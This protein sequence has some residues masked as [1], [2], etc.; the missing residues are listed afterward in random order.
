MRM[1]IRISKDLS[2]RDFIK[3]SALA[4]AG[5]MIDFRFDSEQS[6]LTRLKQA[7][8]GLLGRVFKD[9]TASYGDPS[10]AA[11]RIALHNYN[12]VLDLKDAIIRKTDNNARELWYRLGDGSFIHSHDIQP[13]KN[14]LYAPQSEIP[15]NGLLAEVTVPYT[16]AWNSSTNGKKP[17]QIFFYGSTHWVYGFGQDEQ[18]N[19]YYLVKEDR[20]NHSYYVNATHMR[21]VQD[22][23]LLPISELIPLDNKQ[24]LIDLQ[25]QVMIAYEKNEPVYMS[26]L[27]SGQLKGKTDLSTPMGEY[28]I[29]YKRPSRHMVHSDRAGS[30]GDELY[31][32]PWVSYF[33]DTGI[34]FHGTYW[35][36]NFTRPRSNG[37]INLP[38]NA[39]QWIYRWTQPIVPPREQ[40]Y[41]SRYGT[42]VE[43]I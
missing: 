37:C 12:D 10:A 41:V 35:H 42:K 3:F 27:A 23:E 33:T 40:K 7:N 30:N 36:N 28:I 9:G 21:I 34:A 15:S 38:I 14:Q 5:L 13:V 43:V 16:D 19:S 8:T 26:E 6:L 17:N 18:K 25:S 1:A 2:R 31:G 22:E 39:A 29:N 24:I 32:V 11:R 4:S 20:W